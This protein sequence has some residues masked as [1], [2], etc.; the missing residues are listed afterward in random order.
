MQGRGTP[1]QCMKGRAGCSELLQLGQ[2]ILNHF[3][4][5]INLCET[6][7]LL[8]R[9]GAGRTGHRMLQKRAKAALKN[10]ARSGLIQ[11]L[12]YKNLVVTKIQTT[13]PPGYSMQIDGKPCAELTEVVQ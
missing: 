9:E 3:L 4:G 7:Q 13:T 5:E 11:Q 2:R 1:K 12:A 8:E 10:T 6:D